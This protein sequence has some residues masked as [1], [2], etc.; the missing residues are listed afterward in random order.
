MI[1]GVNPKKE[2]QINEIYA[3]AAKDLELNKYDVILGQGIANKLF[4]YPEEKATLYFTSFR[5]K[6]ILY[7]SKDETLYF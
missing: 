1:F 6:W 5:S 4:L 7:A 2:A 3:K